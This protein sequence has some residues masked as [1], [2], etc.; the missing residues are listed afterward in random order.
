MLLCCV[1]VYLESI[2]QMLLKMNNLLTIKL[3]QVQMT[4]RLQMKKLQNQTTLQ[5]KINMNSVRKYSV[6]P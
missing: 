1:C 4:L 5:S 6:Y 3:N 2:I